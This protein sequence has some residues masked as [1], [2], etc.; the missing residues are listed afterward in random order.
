LAKTR[1]GAKAD[2]AASATL[3]NRDREQR[4]WGEEGTNKRE[5]GKEQ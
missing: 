5:G 3:L 2:D 1:I 4:W